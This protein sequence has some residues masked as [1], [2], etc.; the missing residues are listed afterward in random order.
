MKD[1]ASVDCR[2]DQLRKSLLQ[3]LH[4]SIPGVQG[5]FFLFAL[6]FGVVQLLDINPQSGWADNAL[7]AQVQSCTI[8]RQI[9][10]VGD[11]WLHHIDLV[12]CIL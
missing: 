10:I 6:R 12:I 3:S 9:T 7:Q 4:N 1:I 11:S 2:A 8:G 5:S